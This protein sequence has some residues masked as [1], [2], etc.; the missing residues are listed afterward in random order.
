MLVPKS[1]HR[2]MLTFRLQWVSWRRVIALVTGVEA[3]VK[4][5]LTRRK[6]VPPPPAPSP[7]TVGVHENQ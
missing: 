2:K 3:M 7:R 5:S 4:S 1:V 6:K